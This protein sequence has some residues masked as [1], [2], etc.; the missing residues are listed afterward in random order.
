MHGLKIHKTLIAIAFLTF[1]SSVPAGDDSPFYLL[2]FQSPTPVDTDSRRSVIGKVDLKVIENTPKSLSVYLPGLGE[3]KFQI[4]RV[5]K[6]SNGSMLWTGKA[7][8]PHVGEMQLTIVRG[9]LFGRV[10]V[11]G[12]NFE[13]RP[14]GTDYVVVAS[15]GANGVDEGNDTVVPPT[16]SD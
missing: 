7:A 14:S 2:P 12:Q 6:R 3:K 16:A 1:S 15:G 5:Q 10:S 4:R 9:V 8:K 11:S 13:I